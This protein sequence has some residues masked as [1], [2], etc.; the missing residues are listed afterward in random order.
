MAPVMPACTLTSSPLPDTL[1]LFQYWL[2]STS[3]PSVT[4]WPER[5]VPPV[6]KTIG[7]LFTLEN[8]NSLMISASETGCTTAR[9][10]R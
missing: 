5:L 9:G 7:I 3:M 8:S 10:R 1:I 4:D 2:K 6:R